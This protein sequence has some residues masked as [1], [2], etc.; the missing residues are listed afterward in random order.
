MSSI[1]FTHQREHCFRQSS[2]MAMNK[3]VAKYKNGGSDIVK[4]KRCLP[5]SQMVWAC[6][7][8]VLKTRP[9]QL[10]AVNN[11]LTHVLHKY[12]HLKALVGRIVVAASL[13]Q[14]RLDSS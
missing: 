12:I 7:P 9:V 5:S 6:P 4:N 11:I 13:F 3:T 2:Q 10:S 8:N 1:F 14:A